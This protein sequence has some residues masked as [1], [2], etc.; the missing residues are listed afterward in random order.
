MKK[1]MNEILVW[2][3]NTLIH[4]SFALYSR[5][6]FFKKLIQKVYFKNEKRWVHWYEKNQF[7]QLVFSCLYTFR[8]NLFNEEYKIV[9]KDILMAYQ[10]KGAPLGANLYTL[11]NNGGSERI[12]KIFE[13]YSNTD[14]ENSPMRFKI[15]KPLRMKNQGGRVKIY[16][17]FLGKFRFWGEF[18]LP[19][20][21][22]EAILHLANGR[23]PRILGFQFINE[24]NQVVPAN[25]NVL[26]FHERP[27]RD[28]GRT[29]LE[30]LG[31][32]DLTGSQVLGL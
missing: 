18:Q 10:K 4:F 21:Q 17:H 15:I 12:N 28:F 22:D 31:Y 16:Y 24:Q 14:D 6:D 20:K 7:I 3:I 11:F 1:R 25:T 9:G 5:Y 32:L 27:A 19:K 29:L 2:V 30:N 13:K 8:L 26:V 23:G